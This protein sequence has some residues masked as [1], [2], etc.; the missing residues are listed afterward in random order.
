[1]AMDLNKLRTLVFEKSGIK[2]DTTD[3]IFALVAL[4]EAVL[5]ECVEPH[6][7]VLNDATDQLSARTM[8]LLDASEKYRALL[9]K[10]GEVSETGGTLSLAQE[11]ADERSAANR[12]NS[13]IGV[14]WTRW[15]WLAAAGGVALLSAVL[16]AG[17]QWL[18]APK[19]APAQ[20]APANPAPALTPEQVLLIQNGEKYNRMW[21][22]LDAKTQAQIQ[23]LLQQP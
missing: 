15:H 5:S 17:A 12:R 23:A 2:V 7:A 21:T 3:P 11:L 18:I 8:Q 14:D 9:Q 19:Q 1:M 6:V 10:L 20:V 16:T 22:K 4:N 13:G